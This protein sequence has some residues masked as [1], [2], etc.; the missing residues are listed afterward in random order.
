MQKNRSE[1]NRKETLEVIIPVYNE[2]ECLPE[3]INRLLGLI[4]SLKELAISF[5][6]INDGSKDK[7]LSLLYEYAKRHKYFKIIDLSRNFGHQIAITA[8]MESATADYVAIID[9]DL[10]DPPE[11]IK[12]MY[13][14]AKNQGFDVVYGKRLKRK[15]ESWFKL[16]TAKLFYRFLSKMCDTEILTDTG[17]F[18]LIKKKVLNSLNRMPEHHRF[19]RGMVP[20]VGFKHTALYY[21]RDSRYAG[22]TKYPLSK[23]LQFASD[24]IFSFS[25]V[26]L[27]VSI[28]VG[29]VVLMLGIIGA[30]I[31][32]I[33]KIFTTFYVPGITTVIATIVIIGGIQIIMMGVMGSYIGRIFEESKNRPLYFI[34]DKTN[35][36]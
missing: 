20:W 11:L 7:S 13:L 35:F 18:R 22:V 25:R 14:K 2:E 1:S 23:M 29:M 21:N 31:L 8:G 26:P 24:A 33:L 9:A 12:D 28:Y 27:S 6:F 32:V 36:N 34:N 4:D 17:D 15:G 19:I 10:Q 30:A 3:L 16:L 5:I